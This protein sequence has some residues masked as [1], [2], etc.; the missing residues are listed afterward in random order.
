MK[1]VLV[2]RLKKKKIDL[3][4]SSNTDPGHQTYIQQSLGVPSIKNY[5]N[6][7]GL[8]VLIGKAKK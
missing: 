7:L 3:F 8:L 6:Y 4:F 5:E 2:K 1:K